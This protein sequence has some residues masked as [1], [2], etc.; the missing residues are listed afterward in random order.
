MSRETIVPATEAFEVIIDDDENRRFP[1]IA[2]SIRRGR[3]PRAITLTGE[4][5]G[6]EVLIC[7][8]GALGYIGRT[9]AW[10][11]TEWEWRQAKE[12]GVRIHTY[13]HASA[14]D[15]LVRRLWRRLARVYQKPVS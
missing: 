6:Y 14:P 5:D 11:A 2:W 10:F 12:K 15:G 8:G 4:C 7:P 3:A 1:V 13:D 9:R